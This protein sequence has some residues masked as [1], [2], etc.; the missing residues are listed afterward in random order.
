MCEKNHYS[1]IIVSMKHL[2]NSTDEMNSPDFKTKIGKT[3]SGD[4]F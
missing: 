2:P 4:F 1:Q 3:R